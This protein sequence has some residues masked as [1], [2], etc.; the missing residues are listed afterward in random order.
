MLLVVA[1][2]LALI[3]VGAYQVAGPAA[4][5]YAA[6]VDNNCSYGTGG[7]DADGL[8]WF[9]FTGYND[10]AASSA[11]GQTFA[12]SIPGGYTLTFTVNRT[13]TAGS[14]AVAAAAT[15][16]WSGTPFGNPANGGQYRG[17]AG[18]PALYAQNTFNAP[19]NSGTWTVTLS[20]LQ[21]RD[22]GGQVMSGWTLNGADAESENAG[23]RLTF[24]TNGGGW[25]IV[26][27]IPPL[28]GSNQQPAC[29][30]GLTGQGT[31]ALICTGAAGT[32]GD[33]VA[34]TGG[35]PTQVSATAE[36]NYNSIT[37]GG[38]QSAIAF[39]IST[40]NITLNKSVAGRV[41]ATDQFALSL[42]D[43]PGTQLGSAATSGAATSATTGSITVLPGSSYLLSEEAAGS[44]NL[45]NYAQSWACT[46]S[47]SGSS[48]VLPASGATG[49][50]QSIA[51]QAG[52]DIS[53]TL[54]NRAA[55]LPCTGDS[56]YSYVDSSTGTTGQVYS[57]QTSTVGSASVTSTLVT[58]VPNGSAGNALGITKGGTAM[59]AVNQ[60]STGANSAVIHG[61]D[62]ATGVWSTYTGSSLAT[63]NFP[64]GAVDPSTGIYYY[65]NYIAGTTTTSARALLFG[66]DTT[67]N[68]RITGPV[69]A[70]FNLPSGTQ[71]GT[72]APA[73]ILPS[74]LRATCTC[75]PPTAQRWPSASSRDRF[76]P[77]GPR[78][79]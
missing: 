51:P 77:P 65:V 52:D 13:A 7:T 19:F 38:G 53:C 31:G 63:G 23:D 20:N 36:Q 12:Q 79:V 8:C 50:S 64:A 35:A 6:E 49:T 16:T 14:P 54:T 28:T 21:V 30:G 56:I 55:V 17:I 74:M 61:Y 47:T 10:T 25:Q 2:V 37:G 29:P 34:S 58:T 76:R 44:T 73:A 69:I 60:A 5:A 41:T 11:A 24:N 4:P 75:W 70:N 15:P 48:T 59:Y 18:R 45:G 3:G 68:T 1:F 26:N 9:D 62:A 71:T 40:A 33:V 27:S 78:T 42:T 32:V 57:L 39:A 72:G 66:F 22:A 43:A 46:N 67:T